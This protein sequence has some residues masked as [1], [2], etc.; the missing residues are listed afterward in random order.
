MDRTVE[1]TAGSTRQ[2]AAAV[3]SDEAVAVLFAL[4]ERARRFDPDDAEPL[5]TGPEEQAIREAI[6]ALRYDPAEDE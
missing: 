3:T 1:G 5:L 2:E 4:L 6:D